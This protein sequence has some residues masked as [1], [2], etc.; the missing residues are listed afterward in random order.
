MKAPVI[1]NQYLITTYVFCLGITVS[2]KLR[3]VQSLLFVAN[4]LSYHPKGIAVSGVVLWPL[5]C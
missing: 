4:I 3:S 5:S 2:I 1:V